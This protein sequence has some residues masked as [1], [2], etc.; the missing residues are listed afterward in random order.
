MYAHIDRVGLI[1]V[2]ICQY[3]KYLVCEHVKVLVLEPI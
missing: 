3:L 2:H 1:G